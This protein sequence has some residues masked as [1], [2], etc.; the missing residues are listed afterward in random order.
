MNKFSLQR[1]TSKWIFRCNLLWGAKWIGNKRYDNGSHSKAAADGT[2]DN[3]TTSSEILKKSYAITKRYN[4][5]S[6]SFIC[7]SKLQSSEE[8]RPTRLIPLSTRVSA[9]SLKNFATQNNK[10]CLQNNPTSPVTKESALLFKHKPL[11]SDCGYWNL[12]EYGSLW[13][14][15]AFE[16]LKEE[17]RLDC[18]EYHNKNHAHFPLAFIE[19][20]FS[21]LALS[22]LVSENE[23]DGNSLSFH[24][25]DE[26]GNRICAW[27]Q[28]RALSYVYST[29]YV[30]MI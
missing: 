30:W 24:G 9:V 19:K 10:N 4:L 6:C 11:N 26:A 28:H 27:L 21:S 20:G 8:V 15:K 12:K 13:Q 25:K 5:A 14:P 17:K 2:L 7:R 1:P 3:I 16:R 23:Y 29:L 22:H 18:N